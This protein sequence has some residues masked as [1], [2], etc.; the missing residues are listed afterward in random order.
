LAVRKWKEIP[1]ERP[2]LSSVTCLINGSEPIK[3]SSDR[4]FIEKFAP[5]GLNPNVFFNSFGMA[6][7]T[8]IVTSP[9][10]RKDNALR[11][12]LDAQ[13]IERVSLGVPLQDV[14]AK[15]V[16]PETRQELP[17]DKVGEFWL[18]G[19]SK[20]LGY[21]G[22]EELTQAQFNAQIAGDN[23]GQRFLR[24]GDLLFKHQGEFYFAGRVKDIIIVG[25]RNYYPQDIEQTMEDTSAYVRP[26]CTAAF[27]LDV[28]AGE[29]AGLVAEIE[30]KDA[31]VNKTHLYGQ[32]LLQL[33]QRVLDEHGIPV[34]VVALIASRSIPKTTS[35]KIQR[36]ATKA[37]LLSGKLKLLALQ[38]FT[39]E[40]QPLPPKFMQH[41]VHPLVR[42]RMWIAI[43]L[44]GVAGAHRFLRPGNIK[45]T[46]AI[47][48]AAIAY[49]FTAS[50]WIRQ[51]APTLTF[52]LSSAGA[53]K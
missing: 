6:E 38:E 24:T 13:G 31:S 53:S 4:N 50:R 22:R 49:Y 21:W 15:I 12:V 36:A 2:D 40:G 48:L 28:E 39:P 41:R 32:L 30:I 1:G 45:I 46:M 52:R 47:L 26:G 27:A 9:M 11:T 5:Y 51:K 34:R 14:T 19:P 33:Q 42:Y 7:F 35:G 43:L 29:A 3:M 44:G 23:S 17:E 37:K 20:A 25:G 10:D 8:L 18:D 16:D